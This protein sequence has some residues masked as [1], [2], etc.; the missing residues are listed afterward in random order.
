[1][2]N[3]SVVLE[4]Q[5]QIRRQVRE[6]PDEDRAAY[7]KLAEKQIKDQDTYATLNYIFI[8]GLHHFYLGKW[9]LGLMNISI[10][11]AG[12]GCFFLGFV[13]VS[14]ALILGIVA[15]EVYELFRSEVIVE[16]HNNEISQRL[17]NQIVN[18]SSD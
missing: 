14:I 10:F 18:K 6:L 3:K 7:Y 13:E 15:F 4:Q 16:N 5:E 1:M 2:L 12:V 9:Q 11:W 8:A 17:I